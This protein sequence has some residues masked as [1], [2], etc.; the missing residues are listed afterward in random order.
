M[1]FD[2]PD[3]GGHN[4]CLRDG[5]PEQSRL[6]VAAGRGQPVA[7]SIG[8]QATGTHLGEDTT[9]VSGCPRPALQ[10]EHGGALCPGGS[11]GVRAVGPAVAVVG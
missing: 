9:P 2:H 4:C 8:V 5:A 3:I 6:R 10:E 1:P 7:K 11:A